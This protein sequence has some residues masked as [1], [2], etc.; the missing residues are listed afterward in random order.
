[1]IR[2][3]LAIAAMSAALILAAGAATLPDDRF[4][5][6]LKTPGRPADDLKRDA[7]DHPNQLLRLTGM[8]SGAV[9]ADVLAA[10]GYFSELSSY[11]VGPSGKVLLINNKAFEDWSPGLKDRL[12]GDR[13]PNVVRQTMELDDLQLAPDSVDVV[14][15]IKVYHDLYWVDTTGKWPKV[16]VGGVLDQLHRALKRGGMLLLVDHAARRGHG[17]SD[18]STLHRV[19]EKFAIKDL[20]AHGFRLAERSEVLRRPDDGQDQISYKGEMV[21]KTDRF[22]LLFRKT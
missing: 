14:L 13:L 10:D 17:K 22:V 16:N 7:I 19:E 9:V 20:R 15:L 1:M 2:P 4:D 3:L 12:Q 5:E 6:A 8:K 11:L 21:G 18:A